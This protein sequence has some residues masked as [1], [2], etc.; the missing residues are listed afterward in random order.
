MYLLQDVRSASGAAEENTSVGQLMEEV[1]TT[2]VMHRQHQQG[3]AELEVLTLMNG[4]SE[5]WFES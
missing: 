5:T 1:C 2:S 3:L 4:D